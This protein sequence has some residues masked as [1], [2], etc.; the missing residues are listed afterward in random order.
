MRRQKP[1]RRAAQ[2][3]N[4]RFAQLIKDG[5][6]AKREALAYARAADTI[7]IGGLMSQHNLEE[8]KALI[9]RWFEEVWNKGRQDAIAEMFQTS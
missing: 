1:A 2:V 4:V 9:R 8:N 7:S 3:G 6:I 5:V